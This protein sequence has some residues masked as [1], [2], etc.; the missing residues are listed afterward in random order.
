[1][2]VEFKLT[3]KA[4]GYFTKDELIAYVEWITESSCSIYSDNPFMVDDERKAEILSS[5]LQI[6]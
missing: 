2:E 4:S 3:I 5:D 1:M 6:L